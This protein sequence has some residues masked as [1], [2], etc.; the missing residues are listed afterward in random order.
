MS[1]AFALTR[2]GGVEAQ[3]FFE[4]FSSTLFSAPVYKTY[5]AMIASQN[6]NSDAGFKMPLAAKDIRLVLAA[7]EKLTVPMPTASTVREQIIQAIG[8][9]NG[10]L[11][12][13]ALGKVAAENAGL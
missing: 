7:A 11:D 10:N 1:E 6:Y 13:S 12:W 9:G 5:G 8:R 4:I 3:A 2:K